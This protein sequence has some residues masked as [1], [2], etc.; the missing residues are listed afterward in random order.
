MR[1][2]LA[3]AVVLTLA[4]APLADRVDDY[5][6]T[7]LKARNLPGASV[8]VVQAGRIVKAEGYGLASL[9]LD[10]PATAQTVYE[11]G[12]ISKQFAADAI[13]LL[14]EDGKLRLD[15]LLSKYV[16]STP[17]AWAPIT[18]RHILTHTAGLADFDT[19]DI[20]F[21]YR[22]EYTP[23]EFVELLGKQPLQFVPGERWNYTNAFPLLGMVIERVSGMSYTDFVQSRIFK[24]LKL[25]SA[26]FKIAGDVVPHRADGY[27]YKDGAFRHGETLRPAIIAPNGGVMMNVIDFA[28]WD[29]ALTHGQL[30]RPE[31]LKEMTTPVR[32]NDGR[33][34]S[35]GLGWFMDQFN[36]HRFGA[37]WGTTVTGHSA[38]IRRYVDDDVTVI[39]L[40]NVDDAGLAVDAM[41]KRIADMFVPGVVIH[42]LKPA[43]D[44][45]RAESVR[46]RNVVESVGAG[47][48]DAGAPGLAS[49]LPAAVRERIAKALTTAT[50]FEF[51]GEERVG[52]GHFNL[53]PALAKNR[54][55]RATT[56]AGMRYFTIRLSE[57]GKVLGVLIEE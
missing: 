2:L 7:Q 10:A 57:D 32:L 26:R 1:V 23:R 30:L 5:V 45:N 52:S 50:A 46:L 31:S 8:A 39:V 3:A 21:S 6:R 49:R 53:D 51:L 12:S 11:I 48:E 41:S 22:R 43:I 36:G 40:G 37:H 44:P 54:W 35:H 4:A 19:G 13:L 15:D 47:V 9:E 18:L 34:V 20:G 24:P 38:V 33:T 17:A 56:P 16:D 55:Y 29:I 14:V 27:L 25:D 28:K 42:G